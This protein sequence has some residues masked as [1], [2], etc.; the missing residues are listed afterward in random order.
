MRDSEVRKHY[1][2]EMLGSLA[3]YALILVIAMSQESKLDPGPL[4]T[5]LLVSPMI[6]FLLAT[7]AVARQFARMDEYMRIFNLENIAIAGAV[8]AGATFTYGFLE[9][10][11][12]PLLS[13][14]TVWPLFGGVWGLVGLVRG[15]LL[16]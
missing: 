2:R 3:I 15:R 16:R 4:R 14:F 10:A 12:Y 9:N 6:G 5:A 1:F 8:T 7:W 11:G 13:M